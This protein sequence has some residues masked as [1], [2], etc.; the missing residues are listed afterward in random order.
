[1]KPVVPKKSQTNIKKKVSEKIQKTGQKN[2]QKSVPTKASKSP[3]KNAAKN[4]SKSIAKSPAKAAAKNIVKNAPKKLTTRA[5]KDAPQKTAADRKKSIPKKIKKDTGENTAGAQSVLLAVLPDDSPAAPPSPVVSSA[6][7]KETFSG[8]SSNRPSLQL[9]LPFSERRLPGRLHKKTGGFKSERGAPE[10]TPLISVITVVKND[11]A[12]LARTLESVVNQR[13]AADDLEIL[14]MDGGASPEVRQCVRAVSASAR[15]RVHHAWEKDG[16]IYEGM[17]NA[18][19][20]ARGS[21]LLFLNTGD[22]LASDESLERMAQDV[23]RAAAPNALSD[24]CAYVATDFYEDWNGQLA[25]RRAVSPA[26]MPREM[27]SSHQALF[28]RADV[29]KELGFDASYVVCA[30]AHQF[31]RALSAGYEVRVH[32]Y[33]LSVVNARGFATQHMSLM[34]QEKLCITRELYP[35]PLHALRMRAY[36]ASCYA[37]KYIRALLPDAA[38]RMVRKMRRGQTAKF[39]APP[40]AASQAALGGGVED[41][42]SSSS[43]RGIGEK[44]RM[45]WLTT[46]LDESAVSKIFFLIAEK[47][48]RHCD[49]TFATIAPP[50]S[51]R[52]AGLLADLGINLINLNCTKGRI[53]KAARELAAACVHEGTQIIHAHLGRAYI[54]AALAKKIIR[55]KT[56]RDVRLLATFHNEHRYFSPLTRAALAVLLPRFDSV[57]AVSGACL[58]SY[59]KLLARTRVPSRVIYNPVEYVPFPDNPYEAD[60]AARADAPIVLCP[61][62]FAPGKGQLYALRMFALLVKAYPKA[63]LI[64]AGGGSGMLRA[65]LEHRARRAG[66][67]ASVQFAGHVQAVSGYMKY[68]SLVVFPSQSE[69]FGLVPCEAFLQKTPVIMQD[70]ELARELFVHEAWM[71]SCKNARAFCDAVLDVLQRPALYKKYATDEYASISRTCSPAAVAAEYGRWYESPERTDN[72]QHA[73]HKKQAVQK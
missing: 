35:G 6:P 70:S 18:L 51:D 61:A 7:P 67:A 8:P 44:K 5:P 72:P 42:G 2:I 68:A 40:H 39:D 4:P 15:H 30:D 54:V 60:M 23:F 33:A 71:V 9:S 16:G 47:L 52:A 22:A 20:R 59:Q 57:S 3:V 66:L 64:F 45:L 73:E 26:A 56:G 24:R 11:A 32:H 21:W 37:K 13:I 58:R 43:A 53:Q 49:I 10:R 36:V 28:V 1:M 31:A 48:Q 14:V 65:A 63:R 50:E 34:M 69:G 29:A 38:V 17:N 19:S 55:K 27:S 62:R 25:L 46:A 41:S 12:G